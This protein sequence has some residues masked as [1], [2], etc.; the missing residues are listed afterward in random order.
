MNAALCS[1]EGYSDAEIRGRLVADDIE[2]FKPSRSTREIVQQGRWLY[3]NT[4]FQ[5]VTVIRLNYDFW[6]EIGRAD[7]TTE[8]DEVPELNEDGFKYYVCF[9]SSPTEHPGWVDAR[10]STRWK[11]PRGGPKLRSRVRLSGYPD[12]RLI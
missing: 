3:D 7:G 8:A 9:R 2:W 5:P 12:G 10:D 6:Y 4:V 11:P 1:H